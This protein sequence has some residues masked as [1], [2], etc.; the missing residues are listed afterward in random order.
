MTKKIIKC[1]KALCLAFLFIF[2]SSSYAGVTNEYNVLISNIDCS[3]PVEAI[4]SQEIVY[5][6]GIPVLLESYIYDGFVVD[7][8]SLLERTSLGY[9][10][11]KDGDII[12]QPM[13]RSLSVD[14]FMAEAIN[15]AE[16]IRQSSQ[17]A[18]D[19]IS[20]L[21]SGHRNVS[22]QSSSIVNGP[23]G[24]RVSH[25]FDYQISSTSDMFGGIVNT[26]RIGNGGMSATALQIS[27]V[28]SMSLTE[29]V[30]ISTLSTSISFPP[31]F[32]VGRAPNVRSRTVT[33]TNVLF[34]NSTRTGFNNTFVGAV[35]G[36]PLVTIETEATSGIRVG[37]GIS[38]G[39]WA[40]V[41]SAVRFNGVS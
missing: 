19:I 3:I 2:G 1:N 5:I 35:F 33:G 30:Q 11:V 18:S 7:I 34:V 40:F 28:A 26:V 32:G 22:N 4:I 12:S 10:I 16:Q 25:W 38:F 8:G 13:P 27:P 21:S 23:P 37:Q 14:C 15:T 20:P 6:S 29:H 39:N 24:T 36:T 41:R 31:G 9:R 17:M